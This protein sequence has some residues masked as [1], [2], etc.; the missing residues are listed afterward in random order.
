MENLQR[1]G[2]DGFARVSALT[3]AE[4]TDS[5]DSVQCH[6]R[7]RNLVRFHT[8]LEGP[9]GIVECALISEVYR[10]HTSITLVE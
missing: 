5:S 2:D 10:D 6:P 4:A 8:F 9:S 7:L 1:D 3:Q